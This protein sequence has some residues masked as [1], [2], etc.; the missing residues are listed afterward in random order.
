VKQIRPAVA[1]T[2]IISIAAVQISVVLLHL[3]WT[4]DKRNR[5]SSQDWSLC[6]YGWK[7]I[8]CIYRVGIVGFGC[9][10][11]SVTLVDVSRGPVQLTMS[12]PSNLQENLL[13]CHCPLHF[14][15]HCTDLLSVY[16]F[17]LVCRQP[18]CFHFLVCVDFTIT[19]TNNRLSQ[20]TGINF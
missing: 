15:R 1:C 11:Q 16:S 14:Q 8:V 3:C 6:H 17:L 13:R 7:I 19:V 20:D 10:G 2:N 18:A 12:V 4:L 5:G 9:V